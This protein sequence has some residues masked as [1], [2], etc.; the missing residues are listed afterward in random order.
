MIIY[1]YHF[2][3]DFSLFL[4]RRRCFTF[5]VLCG[6]HLFWFWWGFKV[7]FFIV[8]LYSLRVPYRE[9]PD[10]PNKFLN[11]VNILADELLIFLSIVT[12]DNI[13]EGSLPNKI[14]Y[15]FEGVTMQVKETQIVSN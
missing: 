10:E 1:V 12:K 3:L 2:F 8:E 14:A 5:F 6:F 7:K 4:R 11:P 9:I 13:S 15:F